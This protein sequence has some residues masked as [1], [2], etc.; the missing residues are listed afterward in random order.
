MH[1]PRPP[2]DIPPGLPNQQGFYPRAFRGCIFVVQFLFGIVGAIALMAQLPKLG[3][4]I[5]STF[6][7]DFGDA[8]SHIFASLVYDLFAY[9]HID[10]G[11]RVSIAL[12]ALI[13]ISIARSAVDRQIELFKKDREL[14]IEDR[15]AEYFSEKTLREAN[16][17]IFKIAEEFI[18]VAHEV[19]VVPI[20]TGRFE[21]CSVDDFGEGM[22]ATEQ[23]F[24]RNAPIGADKE[25]LR[26]LKAELTIEFPWAA[27]LL[28]LVKWFLLVASIAVVVLPFFDFAIEYRLEHPE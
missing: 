19:F 27:R 2:L 12:V 16:P 6:L 3:S 10:L 23:L 26:F 8:L 18:T 17:K 22:A 25:L 28:F 4:L 24:V 11:K 20:G 14:E 1:K 7:R 5:H 15:L 9:F 21:R 13:M